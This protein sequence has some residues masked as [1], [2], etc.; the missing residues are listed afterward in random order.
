MSA[1]LKKRTTG[2]ATVTAGP[3][4]SDD[5][6]ALRLAI[7]NVAAARQRLVRHEAA[8]S[9][10]SDHV[11]AVE[12]KL[13][14]LSNAVERAQEKFTSKIAAAL[15]AGREPP[16]SGTVAE[17]RCAADACRDELTAARAAFEQLRSGTPDI[18]AEVAIA[19][20]RAV[21]ASNTLLAEPLAL[22]LA[23]AKQARCDL[24]VATRVLDA[25]AIDEELNRALP[26]LPFKDD[27]QR[28]RSCLER[29]ASLGTVLAE[30]KRFLLG[31][32]T[33]IA[34]ADQ[35]KATDTAAA[36]RTCRMRL[37]S[38]PDAE[39]PPRPFR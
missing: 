29:E 13:T 5:R 21:A 7:S 22:W 18:A 24:L 10:A 37:R 19:D 25:I 17:A 30:V 9:A 4:A 34:E 33:D 26:S 31:I 20:N 1:L 3:S 23:K 36:W 11:E 38:D 15:S 35:A 28:R 12:Q 27:V 2:L 16:P 6:A 32:P 39:M 8:T 14:V